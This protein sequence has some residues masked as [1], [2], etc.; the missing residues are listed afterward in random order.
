[1]VVEFGFN[2]SREGV[3]RKRGFRKLPTVEEGCDKVARGDSDDLVVEIFRC[4]DRGPVMVVA[5][6]IV[7]VGVE[8]GVGIADRGK[9]RRDEGFGMPLP[10]R[11]IVALLPGPFSSI[12]SRTRPRRDGLEKCI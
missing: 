6:V 10:P 7:G 8:V 9:G 3:R 5:G 4:W 1:M 2:C 12:L 11:P